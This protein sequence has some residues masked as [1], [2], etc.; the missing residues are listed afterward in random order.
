MGLYWAEIADQNQTEKQLQFLKILLKPDG[1]VLDLA[2]GTGRHS[3]PLTQQGY[4]IVGFDV[5]TNLL[6]IAR[7]RS[8]ELQLVRGDMRFLPFK[9][10]TFDAAISMDTSFGYL[11]S[12]A[13]DIVSLVEV[14]RV[15]DQQGVFVID[16]F[17]REKLT[18]KYQNKNPPAKW[19]EYP[20]FFL[21][22]KRTISP[23][24]GLLRDSWTIKDKES[25]QLSI[26]EHNV[27]LYECSKL[28]SMLEMAGFVVKDVYGWYKKENY[29]PNSPRLILIAE[30]K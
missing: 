15:I 14:K 9:T 18:L 12:E 2:C 22:Q 30:A 21:L 10:Q 19:K 23:Q 26:F 8:K 27:R 24:G 3:I 11:P 13:D 28:E 16:V 29:S 17:N 5:S 20:S 25:G 4:N 7:Q 1:Y 6:Q